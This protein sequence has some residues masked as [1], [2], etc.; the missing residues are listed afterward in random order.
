VWRAGDD[1][2]FRDGGARPLVM[3][4]GLLVGEL[5]NQLERAARCGNA[6]VV[7]CDV[8]VIAGQSS[9]SALALIFSASGSSWLSRMSSMMSG[10]IRKYS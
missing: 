8:A 1:G 5:G 2:T 4:G 7:L 9:C 10:L 6:D 3:P